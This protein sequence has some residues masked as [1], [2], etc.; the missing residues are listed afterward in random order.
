MLFKRGLVALRQSFDWS[1]IKSVDDLNPEEFD[2]KVMHP[3]GTTRRS[4]EAWNVAFKKSF[5]QTRHELKLLTLKNL[6]S[7]KHTDL[8]LMPRRTRISSWRVLLLSDDDD[9]VAPCWLERLPADGRK[10]LFCRWQSVRFNGSF[11]FR[12]NSR[13]YSFTNNY[14]VFPSARN[15]Y[16]LSQVYQH[17]DQNEIHSQLPLDAVS[18]IDYPLTVTHKHPA[19]ANTMRQLLLDS[20]WDVGVL[21]DSVKN[22]L[23]RSSSLLIPDS[24]G[25]TRN[26]IEESLSIFSALL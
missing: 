19:S 9:W 23:E 8:E 6:R 10:L 12:P 14:C 13:E 15:S 4:V 21:R 24:L 16:A 18:Y 11:Y 7:L 2:A 3:I 5:F 17:F 1:R 22:F 20:D 26:L 25:W